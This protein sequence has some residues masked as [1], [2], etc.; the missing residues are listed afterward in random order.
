MEQL[1]KLSKFTQENQWMITQY[2][3]SKSAVLLETH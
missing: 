1:D 3:A 2:Q